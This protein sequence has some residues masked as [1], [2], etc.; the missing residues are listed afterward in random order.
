MPRAAYPLTSRTGNS[1]RSQIVGGRRGNL[2]VAP[3]PHPVAQFPFGAGEQ[4][5]QA[6]EVGAPGQRQVVPVGKVEI[7]GMVGRFVRGADGG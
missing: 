3:D 4:F 6:V 2:R 7:P 1:A 5:V